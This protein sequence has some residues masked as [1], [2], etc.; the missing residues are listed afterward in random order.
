LGDRSDEEK[1]G[2][3]SET[4]KRQSEGREEAIDGQ[5]RTES[6]ER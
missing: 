3:G 2:G 5:N 1:D 4:G 6:G